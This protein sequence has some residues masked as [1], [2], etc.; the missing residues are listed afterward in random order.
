MEYR[1]FLNSTELI[2]QLAKGYVV[3]QAPMDYRPYT[4]KVKRFT[5]DFDHPEKSKLTF[6][7]SETKTLTVG[8][9]DHFERF[10]TSAALPESTV[11]VV[12]LRV[13]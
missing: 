7:T 2:A 6:W 3:Y 1:G 10:R 12:P 11:D 13:G 8:I 9:V 5:V 4:I